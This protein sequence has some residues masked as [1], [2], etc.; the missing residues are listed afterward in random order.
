MVL[1][2]AVFAA[3]PG[4]ALA[5]DDGPYPIWWS[6]VLELD[7]LD[8]VEQRLDRRLWKDDNLGLEMEVQIDGR[9]LSAYANSC[10]MLKK[11]LAEGFYAATGQG[12]KSQQWFLAQCRAIELLGQAKPARRSFVHDF[13]LDAEIVNSI[14]PPPDGRPCDFR[15]KQLYAND[16]GV[17]WSAFAA[18]DR[19]EVEGEHKIKILQ[20]YWGWR[21]QLVGRADVD[22]DGVEDL[23]LLVHSWSRQ[24]TAGSS[25]FLVLTKFGPNMVMKYLIPDQHY[26]SDR[27]CEPNYMLPNSNLED[28]LRPE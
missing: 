25:E 7:S 22:G 28:D 11:L 14:P 8:N 17:P 6:P 24:G 5:A 12:Y 9:R 10:R 26:C 2:A 15:C 20:S 27:I 3:W 1:A 18:I 16:K 4:S 19:V 21:I 13:T 23:M